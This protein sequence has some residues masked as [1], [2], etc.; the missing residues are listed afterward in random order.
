M[1]MDQQLTSQCFP[2]GSS[3]RSAMQHERA[4]AKSVSN[5]HSQNQKTQVEP[6]RNTQHLSGEQRESA[7]DFLLP[8]R[9]SCHAHGGNEFVEADSF[10]D[11]LLS[12][13]LDGPELDETNASRPTPEVESM[14]A[15]PDPA[16]GSSL[17]MDTVFM[18]ELSEEERRFMLETMAA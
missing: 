2:A 15:A 7:Y 13:K 16:V 17:D 8:E 3:H 18:S 9:K 4:V 1:E 10:H 12:F 11:R 5:T 14:L 6:H